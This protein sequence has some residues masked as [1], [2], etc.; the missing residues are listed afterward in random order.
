MLFY[1]VVLTVLPSVRAVKVLLGNSCE[2]SCQ[3]SEDSGCDKGKFVM[4]LNFSPVQFVKEISIYLAIY[5][6]PL[7][8]KKEILYRKFLVS[9]YFSNIWHPPKIKL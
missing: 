8:E 6:I 4:S 9:N 3:K 7:K 5:L 2:M 1:L